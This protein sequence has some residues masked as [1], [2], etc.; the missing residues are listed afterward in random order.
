MPHKTQQ[1]REKIYES[2]RNCVNEAIEQVSAHAI[3]REPQSRLLNRWEKDADTNH[4][5]QRKTWEEFR[6]ESNR[7]RAP[8]RRPRAGGDPQG[9][10]A[11]H[12]HPRG[13]P[14][15]DDI[16]TKRKILFFYVSFGQTHGM[17][18]VHNYGK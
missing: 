8:H 17:V 14:V 10:P 12:A 4:D 18:I 13:R 7:N 15:T 6:Y 11:H 5:F 9:D 3:S 1:Q 2:N 16:D